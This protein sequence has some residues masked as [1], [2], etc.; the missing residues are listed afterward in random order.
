[1]PAGVAD[2]YAP[3]V[4]AI[5]TAGLAVISYFVYHKYR[6]QKSGQKKV[7]A[8]AAAVKIPDDDDHKIFIYFASQTGTAEGFA[9]EL[10]DEAQEMGLHTEVVDFE[11]FDPDTF[12][13]QKNVI[14]LAA[15]YGEGDPTDNASEFAT[16]LSKEAQPGCLENMKFTVMGLGNRQYVHFNHFAI[17]IDSKLAELGATRIHE[18]GLGDDDADI[19]EDFAKWKDEGLWE[20]VLT[21]MM[22]IRER[23]ASSASVGGKK[24]LPDVR[25]KLNLVANFE[26]AKT[27]LPYDATVHGGGMDVISKF[28]FTADEATVK[29]IRELR[30]EPNPEEGLTTV[31]LDVDISTLPAARYRT[32]DNLEILPRNPEWEVNAIAERFGCE[33]ML[34]MYVGFTR[35]LSCTKTVVK[36]PFPTPCTLREALTLYCDLN[37]HPTKAFV[38]DMCSTEAGAFDPDELLLKWKGELVTVTEAACETFKASPISIG[39]FLQIVPRQKCRAYT[40]SSSNLEH[41]RMISTTVGL[42]HH[43]RSGKGP[44]KGVTTQQ[45]CTSARPGDKMWVQVRA[46]SFRLPA[47]PT[48]PIIMISAGTGIAPMRA[49]MR[50]LT[51]KP[52]PAAK[53]IMLFGCRYRDKDWIYADETK[54]FA[55]KSGCKL[56]TAFSR[57]QAEKIYVQ[58]LVT[59]TAK[60]DLEEALKGDAYVYICGTQSMGRSVIEALRT[61]GA[62]VDKM[63]AEKRIVEELWG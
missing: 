12:V 25:N 41:P 39:E 17:V 28:Y 8:G 16:W 4:A 7:P 53:K 6:D 46:S 57:E 15:T 63:R 48:A 10:A 38:R 26:K 40:I 23:S 37:G 18:L 49:F 52:R 51:I 58:D 20:A 11:E 44:F 2:H 54:E 61:I 21:Q 60:A 33:D 62:D 47:N 55:E 9:N 13:E 45:L 29:D 34:D 24:E 30:Q 14:I 36:K 5:T 43:P 22:G 50:E 32:A 56:F 1:M 27:N 31:H 35:S 19:D 59:T 42:I 3:A